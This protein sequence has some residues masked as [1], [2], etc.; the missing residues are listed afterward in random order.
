[1]GMDVCGVAPI[2][3]KGEYF[4]NNVWWWRPLA[5]YC[6]DVAPAITSQCAYWQSNDGAGLN[7]PASCALAD[8]LQAE[9]DSGR[10]Q[11]YAARYETQRACTPKP[12]CRWCHATGVRRD[13]VA[14][15]AGQHL[16]P[17]PTTDSSHP[18]AGQIGWCNGCDGTGY[19]EPMEAAYPFSVENVQEFVVFLRA[20]GGFQIC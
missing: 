10:T 3:S 12:P 18:R 8:A 9:I 5:A 2:T 7:G 19:E 13:A 16:R 4:R 17:I 1:M 6:C 20:C 15:A 11:A 14:V